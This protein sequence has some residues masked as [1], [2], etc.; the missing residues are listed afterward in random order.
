MVKSLT[1]GSRPPG[2]TSQLC[3]LLAV[4]AWVS[5]STSPCLTFLFCHM[6][7][8]LCLPYGVPLRVG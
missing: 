1:S 8:V 7:V 4:G 3:P 2:C 6:G 5:H